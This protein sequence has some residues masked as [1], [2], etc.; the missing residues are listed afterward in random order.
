MY[1]FC[2]IFWLLS[3][4]LNS[5]FI[6]SVFQL[7]CEAAMKVLRPDLTLQEPSYEKAEEGRLNAAN[8]RA[9]VE[10]SEQPSVLSIFYKFYL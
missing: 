1:F 9:V 3:Y 10:K 7:A 8:A 2:G 6:H 4:F 5:S